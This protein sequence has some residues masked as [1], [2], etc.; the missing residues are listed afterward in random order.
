MAM[1]ISELRQ[2][3]AG[4]SLALPPLRRAADAL[5]GTPVYVGELA[6]TDAFRLWSDLRALHPRSGW[7][8]VLAGKPELLHNVFVGLA[9]E[10][11]PPRGRAEDRAPDG[12]AVL[13]RWAREAEQYARSPDDR[14]PAGEDPFHGPARRLAAHVAPEADPDLVGGPH[15]S[16]LRQE[17][18]A[19]CLVRAADGHDVPALLNW[20]GACNYDIGGAEHRAV[21]RYFHERYGA[22]LV[23]L[24]DQVIELLVTRGPRTPE[25]IAAAALEQYTYCSDI[26][27]QGVGS[28]EELARTQVRCGSWYF[29][30][31]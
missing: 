28:V 27:D 23:T 24:E 11:A 10:F 21:L 26:V 9:P 12:R 16:A 20:L 1:A 22:E 13:V 4:R 25:G 15:I 3:C 29:W 6:G 17:R 18:T 30:W 19:V 8:P 31:D 7:W 5:D 2:L 14:V